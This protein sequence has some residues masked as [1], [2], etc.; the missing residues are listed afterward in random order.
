MNGLLE[1]LSFDIWPIGIVFLIIPLVVLWRRKS[2]FSYILCFTIFG[3]YL[4]R[5][6]QE[7]YFPIEINGFYADDM[8]QEPFMSQVNLIPFSYGEFGTLETTAVTLMQN[9]LLTIPFGFGINFIARTRAKT[10]RWLA[11]AVGFGT[12]LGQL[13]ISLMLGYLYRL[14]DIND[15]LMNTLGVVVGYGLFR[16]FAWGYVWMTRR[17]G[18]EHR[19]LSAYV[20]EVASDHRSP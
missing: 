3:I 4:L 19:G 10:F 9:I 5:A 14:I 18:I 11:P 2:S 7:V 17:F 20:Y 15:V 8:R 1:G 16:A 6:A 12:E 13:A